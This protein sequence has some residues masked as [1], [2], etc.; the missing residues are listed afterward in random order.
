MTAKAFWFLIVA[1]LA[2]ISGA[3][4]FLLKKKWEH[5]SLRVWIG[6]G[7]GF[8]LAVSLAEM[9]PEATLRT[10]LTPLWALIGFLFVHLFE[11]VLPPHF[12]YGD[13]SHGRLK[14]RVGV[15]ATSGLMMHS[16]TDGVAIVAAVQ[17]DP[18]LGWLVLTA[19]VWHKVPGGFTA[20]S[21]ASATGASRRGSLAA[22]AAVGAATIVGGAVYAALP[23]EQWVG[24]ALALSAG[25]LIYVA[26]TDLLPEVNK[27]RSM[28]APLSVLIGVGMF[29]LSHFLFER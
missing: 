3:W 17:V 12:H 15:A 27:R 26:A 23:A 4:L 11:H 28:L 21:V 2:N 24:P 1:A 9:M 20:A 25:S 22:A 29:Y 19:A 13:E 14:A 7:A 8:M 5:E 16:V 6:A 18:A 10:P